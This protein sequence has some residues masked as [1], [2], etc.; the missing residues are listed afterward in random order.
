MNPP[1]T[2]KDSGLKETAAPLLRKGKKVK[3]TEEGMT[4]RAGA[5]C[6][7]S[8]RLINVNLNMGMHKVLTIAVEH[9]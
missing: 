7:K 3:E 2:E 6:C 5:I 1:G 9:K 4:K 8:K